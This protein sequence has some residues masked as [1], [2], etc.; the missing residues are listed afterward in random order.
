MTKDADLVFMGWLRLSD[1][2]KGDV[3]EEIRKFQSLGYL[4]K[5]TLIEKKAEIIT[6]PVG[7]VCPC[8][9]R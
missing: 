4:D 8:C 1:N 3:L 9:G 5:R 6:G 7:L 2:E